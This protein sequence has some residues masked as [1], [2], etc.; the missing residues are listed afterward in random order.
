LPPARIAEALVW[1]V[2]AGTIICAALFSSPPV[3]RAATIGA[4][5][6]GANFSLG[7][8]SLSRMMTL[9]GPAQRAFGL[10]YASKFSFLVAI[11]GVLTLVM[12][13]DVLGLVIG[14]SALPIAM[15]LLLV[16]MLLRRRSAD[17]E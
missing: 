17:K 4:L 3:A 2:V 5:F 16:V 6:C 15:Y 11:L 9:R 12:H 10:L 7:R 8:M 14:F 13:L 1:A